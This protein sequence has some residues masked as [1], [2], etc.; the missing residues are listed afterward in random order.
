M[1]VLA[2]AKEWISRAAETTMA[3]M[4]VV[5]GLG[6]HP[7]LAPQIAIGDPRKR[8]QKAMVKDVARDLKVQPSD[9]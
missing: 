7:Y 1:L 5:L 2:L 4:M 3:K 9:A 6:Q 8:L